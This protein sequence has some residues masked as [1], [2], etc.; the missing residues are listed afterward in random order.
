MLRE[1]SVGVIGPNHVCHEHHV[2]EL[3][4]WAL[5][6]DVIVLTSRC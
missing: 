6:P 3:E 1:W 5:L 2:T 4:V